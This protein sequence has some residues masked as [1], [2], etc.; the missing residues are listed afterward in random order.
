MESPKNSIAYQKIQERY[1]IITRPQLLKVAE[2]FEWELGIK[3][4]RT[5]KRSEDPL[6]RWFIRNWCEIEPNL[7]RIELYENKNL[8]EILKQG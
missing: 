7:C 8:D 5:E 4:S 6:I 2:Y 1:G 3:L